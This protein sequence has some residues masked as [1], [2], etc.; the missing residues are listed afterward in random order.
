MLPQKGITYFVTGG[1]GNK[2]R[3]PIKDAQTAVAVR[4]FQFMY[5]ELHPDR[6]DFWSIPPSGKFLDHGTIFPQKVK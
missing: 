1:G 6:A 4:S 2:L 5:F 3:S